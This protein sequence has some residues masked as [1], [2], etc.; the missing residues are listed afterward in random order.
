METNKRKSEVGMYIID[1]DYNIVNF[2]EAMHQMYP[3]VQL[4]DICYKALA[5][6]EEPCPTCPLVNDNVVF[7][8]P[9]RKEWISANAAAME[10]PGHGACH[11]VQFQ[12]R[13]NIGGSK[14]E[15]IRLEKVDNHVADI[16]GTTMNG[17]VIGAYCEPGSPIFYANE[18]LVALMGY[19][20]I[21]QLTEALNGLVV[22]MIHPDDRRRV[23]RELG[24]A[25]ALNAVFETNYRIQKKDGSWIRIVTKG[26]IIETASGKLATL[27]VCMDVSA[28]LKYYSELVTKNEELIRKDTITEE[29]MTKIPGCYHRC[30]TSEGFPFLYISDSFE[31]AV[32]WTREEI[33]EELDNKFINLVW[34]EDLPLFDGLL[35]QIKDKGQGSSIYRI[36]RKD[37]TY[38]W[39]QDSTMYIEAGEESFYQCTFADIT[40]YIDTLNRE[41]EK[42]EVG[43]RAKSAFLFNAS[44]DIRTPMNA[45][46]GYT[47][48]LKEHP[49]Q[50]ELVRETIAKI[51]QS[52][53]TLMKLLND[54]LELS[55]IE[56]GKEEIDLIAID[57]EEV[58]VKLYN[59]VAPEIEK[60]GLSFVQNTQASNTLVWCDELKLTQIGMNLLS[61]ARK[62]TPAGGTIT[63]GVEQQPCERTGYANYRFY[64]R[65]TGIGMSREFVEKAFEQFERERTATESGVTGSGLGLSII[66]KITELLGGTYHIQSELGK[67]TEVSVI[68]PLKIATKEDISPKLIQNR[69]M[70]FS[71]KRILLVEDNEFNREISRYIL[72][73]IGLEVE[74]AE[75][76]SVAVG[77]VMNAP[78]GHYD[79]ILM[80]IQMPIMDGYTAAQEIR[81]IEDSRLASIPIVALTANAFAEDKEKSLEYGMNGHISKPIDK[82]MLMHEMKRLI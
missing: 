14:A 22:N 55:R 58:A 44:H 67:G 10:Y 27:A 36:R 56:S 13:K 6:C 38:R 2:N 72:E 66:R 73:N 48:I 54:V 80:D 16:L 81:H 60:A 41:K 37:G 42:A 40:E 70:D 52:G 39:V 46:Q 53:D 8:N 50:V 51:E 28:F 12:I 31:E 3:E 79:L 26:K 4:G 35:E 1:K 20:D 43:S 45:I 82:D 24:E 32:G 34:P 69:D 47:Q 71:G 68:L 9:V 49:D 17:A 78:A 19:D 77:K 29:I 57:L 64:V 76:G 74:E 5:L 62:F 59:M 7:F 15:I 65:D 61:N 25:P 23:R 63:Y 11:N 75:N 30:S 33:R 21:D 18:E